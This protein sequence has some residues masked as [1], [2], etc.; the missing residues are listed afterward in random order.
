M[1]YNT[2]NI[3]ELQVFSLNNYYFVFYIIRCIIC[4]FVYYI[5]YNI[6]SQE[7]AVAKMEQP[8]VCLNRYF[9]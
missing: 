3:L 5:A 6:I 1:I 9:Q 8:A 4:I 2:Y 7:K